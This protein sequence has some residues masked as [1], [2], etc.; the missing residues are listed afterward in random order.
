[1]FEK[2][3][4]MHPDKIADRIA[5]A[6]VDLAYKKADNPKVAVE[7]LVGHGTC[8]VT[9]ESSVTFEE[10]ELRQIV[11]RLTYQGIICNFVLC[12]QDPIL[13][14]NQES[15]IRCGDNGIFRGMPV[16]EEQSTLMKIAKAIYEKFPTDGKHIY[17]V[18]DQAMTICQSECPNVSEL[19]SIVD[20][21]IPY[22]PGIMR[23]N[24]LGNWT[25]GLDVDSGA[26]NRKLGSDMGDAV[27]GGGLHGKDLSKADVTVNILC[28]L[29]AQRLRCPV[30]AIC[31]I[32]D[33]MVTIK[34]LNGDIRSQPFNKMVEIAKQFIDELG[35][36]EAFAEWGLIR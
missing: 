27:T 31:S 24:P 16:T 26:T 28:H 36:F 17:S 11:E 4:P 2:V 18:K 15:A 21:V 7:V 30:T 34:S 25:G 6:I 3:N 8:N 23:I 29:E 35:G 10:E 9:V 19:K 12:P 22:F 33:T 13:A 5:G 1:M 32:G 14:K 20:G